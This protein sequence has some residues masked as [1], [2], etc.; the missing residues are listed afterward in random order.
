LHESAGTCVCACLSVNACVCVAKCALRTSCFLP[1]RVGAALADE[2][3]GATGA[4]AGAEVSAAAAAAKAAGGVADLIT[5]EARGADV[6]VVVNILDDGVGVYVGT[7]APTEESAVSASASAGGGDV[8]TAAV[9]AGL[10]DTRTASVQTR[11]ETGERE[12]KTDASMHTRRESD[13]Q[14]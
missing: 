8:S 3:A 4:G 6:G 1:P 9:A 10:G 7:L 11:E 2:R 14:C 12:R 5:T 13:G